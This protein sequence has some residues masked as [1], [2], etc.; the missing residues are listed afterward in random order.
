MTKSVLA[1][2]PLSW[3]LQTV[4]ACYTYV[5]VL[6]VWRRKGLGS[7]ICDLAEEEIPSERQNQLFNHQLF[8]V[9][10]VSRRD[11]YVMKIDS[12]PGLDSAIVFLC[13]PHARKRVVYA[14]I[15]T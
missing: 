4:V 1:C 2:F 11:V 12:D 14:V 15:Q 7:A 13:R 5:R 3:T 8:T 9:Q 10:F 6:G